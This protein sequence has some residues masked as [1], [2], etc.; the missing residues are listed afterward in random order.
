MNIGQKVFLNRAGGIF[1]TITK[2]CTGQLS[3]LVEVRLSSGT[4][5]VS[6]SDVEVV[7]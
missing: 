1:G 4:V 5:C 2:V 7:A 3:G 6:A